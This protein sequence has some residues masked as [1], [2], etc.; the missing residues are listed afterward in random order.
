MISSYLKRWKPE[1]QKRERKKYKNG[2][3]AGVKVRKRRGNSVITEESQERKNGRTEEARA[4]EW[5]EARG[6]ER[7]NGRKARGKNERTEERQERGC[8]FLSVELT[9][10]TSTEWH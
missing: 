6:E 3:E 1:K 2:R 5:I 7:K 9:S 4:E 10:E 8:C